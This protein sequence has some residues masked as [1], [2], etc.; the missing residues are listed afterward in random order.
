M[1]WPRRRENPGPVW[2]AAG[3]WR[4][5]AGANRI[6]L[7]GRKLAGSDRYS[8]LP[9]ACTRRRLP[10]PCIELAAEILVTRQ[11]RSVEGEGDMALTLNYIYIYKYVVATSSSSLSSSS[12]SSHRSSSILSCH[13]DGRVDWLAMVGNIQP[14]GTLMRLIRSFTKTWHLNVV[15]S[16]PRS[17]RSKQ[18]YRPHVLL[19]E[20]NVE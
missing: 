8:M 9:P 10:C 6:V 5:T 11:L 15:A 14:H 17:H 1:R 12:S 13:R 19:L 3:C 20:W 4:D 7:K 18:L 16:N 2:G